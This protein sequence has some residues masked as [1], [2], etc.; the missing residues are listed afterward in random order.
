MSDSI[1]IRIDNQAVQDALLKVA[2]KAE[3]LRPLM[4]NVAGIMTDATE[5]KSAQNFMQM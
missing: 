3:T 1:E 2:T 4:K 5:Q